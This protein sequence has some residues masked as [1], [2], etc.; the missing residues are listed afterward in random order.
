MKSLFRHE[1][2]VTGLM[3]NVKIMVGHYPDLDIVGML[4]IDNGGPFL[5]AEKRSIVDRDRVLSGYTVGSRLR[6]QCSF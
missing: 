3:R 1:L 4:R 5:F 6:V 2:Q